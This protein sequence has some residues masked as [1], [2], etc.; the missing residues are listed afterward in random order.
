MH[1]TYKLHYFDAAGLAEPIRLAFHANKVP[2]EDIRLTGESWKELK[3]SGKTTFGQVPFLEIDGKG[4][5]QSKPI[6][7]LLC[8]KF[9]NY[10]SNVEDVYRVEAIA[11]FVDDFRTP[12]RAVYMEQDAEKK[13]E[14]EKKYLTEQLPGFLEKLNA[15]LKENGPKHHFFVADRLTL[16]DFYVIA[17]LEVFAYCSERHEIVKESL[18]KV[19]ELDAYFKLH[20]PAFGEYLAKQL[21]KKL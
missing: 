3:E 15:L 7:R 20:K 12:W 14:L 6:L 13:K 10:P 9:G 2:F 1:S 17:Y 8:Q 11:D 19:P 18:A 21:E 5:G 16:A 4:Y